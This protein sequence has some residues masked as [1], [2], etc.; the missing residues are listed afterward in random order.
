[1]HPAP[2]LPPEQGGPR[3]KSWSLPEYEEPDDGGM[4]W[5]DEEEP[6]GSVDDLPPL[7]DDEDGKK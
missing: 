4:P 7:D 5:D 3:R 1:M 2:W 6:W